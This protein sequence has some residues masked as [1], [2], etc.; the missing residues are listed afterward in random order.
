MSKRKKVYDDALKTK[1]ASQEPALT[2][3]K[4]ATTAEVKGAVAMVTSG[5]I[6]TAPASKVRPDAP[7][8]PK[9]LYASFAAQPELK[10]MSPQQVEQYAFRYFAQFGVLTIDLNRLKMALRSKGV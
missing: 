1:A 8:R 9:D 6:M 3:E 5:V 7:A 4:G 10:G 2:F